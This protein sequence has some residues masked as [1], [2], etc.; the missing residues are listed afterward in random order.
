MGGGGGGYLEALEFLPFLTAGL[1]LLCRCRAALIKDDCSIVCQT[2]QIGLVCQNPWKR[3]FNQ[4]FSRTD[5]PGNFIRDSLKL[6]VTFYE[7]RLRASRSIS[8][9]A[10]ATPRTARRRAGRGIDAT[11]AGVP[12]VERALLLRGAACAGLAAGFR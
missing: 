3:E 4:T 5:E 6:P 12:G 8:C 7:V 11:L 9:R 2:T 1:G 10:L